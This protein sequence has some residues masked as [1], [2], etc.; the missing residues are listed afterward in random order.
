MK[1]KITTYPDTFDQHIVHNRETKEFTCDEHYRFLPENIFYRA[2]SYLLDAVAIGIF[3]VHFHVHDHVRIL[4]K[5]N[6][7]AVKR[8]GGVIVHNHVHLFDAPMI[9]ALITR[10]NV[11]RVLTLESNFKIPVAR[12]FMKSIG[13]MPIP[14]HSF[15]A[16]KNFLK[17]VD[18]LLQTHHWISVAPEGYNWPFYPGLRPFYIGAF[19]FAVKNNRPV[20]PI[21]ILF[22]RKKAGSDIYYPILKI[23]PAVYPDGSLPVKEAEKAL[24]RQVYEMMKRELTEFYP[25]GTPYRDFVEEEV[26][27]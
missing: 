17:T 19:R 15:K 22:R 11:L 18:S 12:K 23:L 7:K 16:N 5:E 6:Y 4:G 8:E 3:T 10:L 1:R 26:I 20:L 9:S 24:G 14:A 2:G 27:G 13:C 21:V 25:S